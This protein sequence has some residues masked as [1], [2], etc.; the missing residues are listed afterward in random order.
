MSKY[1]RHPN[2]QGNKGQNIKETMGKF[3]T[4]NT[5]VAAKK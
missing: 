3:S 1:C 5:K 2:F 4:G